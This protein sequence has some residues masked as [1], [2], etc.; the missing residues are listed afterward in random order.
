M[1]LAHLQ[2]RHAQILDEITAAQNGAIMD[3]YWEEMR[4]NGQ[5]AGRSFSNF[6]VQA[7]GDVKLLGQTSKVHIT[8]P[9]RLTL[10]GD[11]VA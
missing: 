7:S 10:Y 5:L 8:N 3:V 6:L 9:R 2:D 4:E 11:V 1:R